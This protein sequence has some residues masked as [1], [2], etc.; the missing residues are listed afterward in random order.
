MG[1]AHRGRER[2]KEVKSQA[3][4][5]SPTWPSP[6]C[7][8]LSQ[9][10]G[11]YSLGPLK[12]SATPAVTYEKA[13]TF[14]LR[15]VQL[16]LFSGT[17]AST[18][19]GSERNKGFIFKWTWLVA[20]VIFRKWEDFPHPSFPNQNFLPWQ[21]KQNKTKQ[22]LLQ[23]SFMEIFTQCIY[24]CHRIWKIKQ[25]WSLH[26]ADSLWKFLIKIRCAQ[27]EPSF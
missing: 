5:E 24:Q 10:L 1:A 7:F 3:E 26:K 22:N 6:C 12:V 17:Q 23:I 4:T 19:P 21:Q 11:Y 8:F 2:R 9:L 20:W 18:F 14:L 13:R 25:I 27:K 15:C 16:N